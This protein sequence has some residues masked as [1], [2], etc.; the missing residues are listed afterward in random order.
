MDDGVLL[1]RDAGVRIT[2][3]LPHTA[4]QDDYV[5][6]CNKQKHAGVWLDNRKPD[7]ETRSKII[8]NVTANTPHAPDR[9]K[10]LT[11]FY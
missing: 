9:G 11:T 5:I 10:K 2:A 7:T 6:L 1:E 3:N 8:R 4:K